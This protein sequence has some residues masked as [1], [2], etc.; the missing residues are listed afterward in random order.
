MYSPPGR[1]GWG[2]TQTVT[3][4]RI[5][6]TPKRIQTKILAWTGLCLMITSALLLV[7]AIVVLQENWELQQVGFWTIVWKMAGAGFLCTLVSFAFLWAILRRLLHPVYQAIELAH[8]I[9]RGELPETVE[10]KGNDEIAGFLQAVQQIREHIARLLD[11]TRRLRQ[12]VTH[13]DF[14]IQE[15]IWQDPALVNDTLE[16]GQQHCW[17]ELL[18]EI[19]L[20]I[21]TAAGPLEAAITCLEQLADGD[22]PEPIPDEYPGRFQMLTQSL[23]RV[24][25]STAHITCLAQDITGGN[26][27]VSIEKRSDSD[28]LIEE[29]EK[30]IHDVEIQKQQLEIQG[31][32]K[33][34]QTELNDVMRGEQSPEGLAKRIITYL[35]GFLDAQ[36]GAVYLIRKQDEQMRLH[37]SAGY[38]FSIRKGHPNV[39]RMGEGLVGQAAL[40]RECLLYADPPGHDFMISADSGEI[41]PRFVLVA[42]LL[43]EHEVTGVLQLGTSGEFTDAQRDFLE[44]TQ[45]SMAIAIHSA[46]TR[47]KMQELLSATQQQAAQLQTQQ[48]QLRHSNEVLDEQAKVL[49]E[50]EQRLQVQQQE[51]LQTNKELELANTYKSK[52]LANMSHEFRTPLNGILGYTQILRRDETL[53]EKQ[54]QAVEVMHHS[55]E[56]LLTLLND[57]LD[58]T[59]VESQK[60]RLDPRIFTLPES[61]DALVNVHQL[62]AQKR[63]LQ[64]SYSAPPELPANVYGDE[65][66]L[67]QVL[68]NLLSNAVKY[69]PEGRV[70]FRITTL[71]ERQIASHELER[72]H[73]ARLENADR[74]SALQCQPS[75]I[76]RVIRLRFLVED[77]GIGIPA[78]CQTKIFEMF[79]QISD[80]RIHT[81]GTGLGLAL[82]QELVRLMGSELQVNSHEQKGSVFW[83]DLDL[84]VLKQES[85]RSFHEAQ[86]MSQDEQ[87]KN[88]SDAQAVLSSEDAAQ[89]ADI[90]THLH[91]GDLWLPPKETLNELYELAMMG[92]VYTLQDHVRALE[93]QNSNPSPF[94][95]SLYQLADDFEVEEL[96]RLLIRVVQGDGGKEL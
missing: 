78:D 59:K 51:L 67:R 41:A 27:P 39:I 57:V 6:M 76:A 69:T 38:K 80:S 11:E 96:Q 74:M 71:G 88:A 82:S 34:G 28:R 1:Q 20:V 40:E 21:E 31:W 49:R 4:F 54:Q 18:E 45:E 68:T 22:I 70:N 16:R 89:K 35:A 62:E 7:Y 55:G 44:Q 13:G 5:I 3:L 73:P 61:L 2:K 17:Q 24:I 86:R 23:N 79:Y 53:T 65:R 95:A 8:E 63:G 32:M 60:M 58:L 25:E 12:A 46:Q 87:K 56:H 19:T 29:F 9:A 52:F 75:D 50:S 48:E 47:E 43:Y 42:P 15:G 92:D 91:D 85:S 93:Q 66:R 81:E 94:L 83:F 37:L 64:F 36:I 10:V 90:L 33:T 26:R 30:T 72:G 84:P 14:N 77:S